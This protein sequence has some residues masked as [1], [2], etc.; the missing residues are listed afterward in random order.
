MIEETYIKQLCSEIQAL[1]KENEKMRAVVQAAQ[2]V[3]K[4]KQMLLV[5]NTVGFTKYW[6]KLE[7]SLKA[8]ENVEKES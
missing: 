4:D 1:R 6:K 5:K 2:E 7:S 3:F 8:L